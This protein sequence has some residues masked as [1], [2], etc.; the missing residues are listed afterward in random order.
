MKFWSEHSLAE[1]S[2]FLLILRECL[3]CGQV[4][5]FVLKQTHLNICFADDVPVSFRKSCILV[6]SGNVCFSCG[7]KLN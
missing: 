5:S 2:C 3:G 4:I 7:V 1:A 6:V